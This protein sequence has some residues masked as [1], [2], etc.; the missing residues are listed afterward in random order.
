MADERTH[1]TCTSTR[2]ERTPGS[3]K[4]HIDESAVDALVKKYFGFLAKDQFARTIQREQALAKDK[5][6]ERGT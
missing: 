5:R 1:Y 4:E 3:R 2:L 6:D